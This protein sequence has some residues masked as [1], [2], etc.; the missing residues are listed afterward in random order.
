MDQSMRMS[1]NKT[2]RSRKIPTHGAIRNVK[3]YFVN[4]HRSNNCCVLA[5]VTKRTG[6]TYQNS[7]DDMASNVN[8]VTG[9]SFFW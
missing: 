8:I 5:L 3:K 4:I 2:G 9:P 1:Q 7:F 6:V